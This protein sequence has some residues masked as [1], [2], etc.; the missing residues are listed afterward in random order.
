[1]ERLKSYEK[2]LKHQVNF[3]M[4]DFYEMPSL[5]V[6]KAIADYNT[7]HVFAPDQLVPYRSDNL[8][9][10]GSWKRPNPDVRLM[11]LVSAPDGVLW[12]L[13]HDGS[14]LKS[15]DAGKTWP[16]VGGKR[17]LQRFAIS[18]NGGFCGVD[19]KGRVYTST[20]YDKNWIEKWPGFSLIKSGPET[21]RQTPPS[22]M[23]LA[24]GSGPDL[25]FMTNSIGII[26]TNK[27]VWTA[28]KSF[29]QEARLMQI[30]AGDK[31]SLWGI[32]ADNHV[33]SCSRENPGLKWVE[34]SRDL[35]LI[36]I[37]VDKDGVP[38]GIDLDRHIVKGSLDGKTWTIVDPGTRKIDPESSMVQ[39]VFASDG[40]LWGIGPRYR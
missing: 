17:G 6:V 35:R 40:A 38:W 39:I 33:F 13:S 2:V 7:H 4:T 29:E 3:L 14:I 11:Y 15:V 19:D 31:G 24:G 36:W 28:N 12:G 27:T 8:G 20:V 1:M 34:P 22:I 10:P 37:T 26:E 25:V 18:S 32:N 9:A 5:D 23:V 21:E 30:A 16:K